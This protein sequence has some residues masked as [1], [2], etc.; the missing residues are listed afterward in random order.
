V[1]LGRPEPTRP[2]DRDLSSK[3][4]V[5]DPHREGWLHLAAA[6]NSWRARYKFV[7]PVPFF[8]NDDPD[9]AD[10][11]VPLDHDLFDHVLALPAASLSDPAAR[12]L[13]H[14]VFPVR[15]A[16]WYWAGSLIF[17]SADLMARASSDESAWTARK[18]F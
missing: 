14:P 9:G 7:F 15:R 6:W 5:L 4:P 17:S 13:P 12:C 10:G 18:N 11:P 3:H 1:P 16:Y 2:S 8:A